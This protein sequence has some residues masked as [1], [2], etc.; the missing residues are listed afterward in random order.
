MSELPPVETQTWD[1]RP[2]EDE[3]EGTR[4]SAADPVL[5]TGTVRIAGRRPGPP[6]CRLADAVTAAVGVGQRGRD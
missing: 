3:A 2:R 4:D 1:R 5:R 6:A